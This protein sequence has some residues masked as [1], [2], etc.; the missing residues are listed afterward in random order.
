VSQLPQHLQPGNITLLN[1]PPATR[2]AEYYITSPEYL[3]QANHPGTQLA[4]I[5]EAGDVKYQLTD[6]KL[7]RIPCL[8]ADMIL[9]QASQIVGAFIVTASM[10]YVLGGR[11][12]HFLAQ[13]RRDIT[14]GEEITARFSLYTSLFYEGRD[15]TVLRKTYRQT[16]VEDIAAWLIK[17]G[18]QDYFQLVP[19]VSTTKEKRDL[20]DRSRSVY[21]VRWSATYKDKTSEGYVRV[22]KP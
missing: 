1:I 17:N 15:L 22:E 21:F 6:Q 13:A 16:A 14:Q 5:A 8:K 20:Y 18:G 12:Y 7:H 9:R 11:E 4:I 3:A 19:A 2:P 10:V